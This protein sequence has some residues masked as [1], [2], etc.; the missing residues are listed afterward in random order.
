MASTPDFDDDKLPTF[1]RNAKGMLS[2]KEQTVVQHAKDQADQM[3][4][5]GDPGGGA[6]PAQ[7]CS[8]PADQFLRAEGLDY[9]IIRTQFQPGDAV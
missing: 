5:V 3:P 8:H 1:G 7:H 6:I 9:I 4:G 2:A